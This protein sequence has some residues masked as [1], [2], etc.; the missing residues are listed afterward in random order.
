MKKLFI[1]LFFTA[2][3]LMATSNKLIIDAKKFEGNDGKGVSIFTGD[4]KLRKQQDKLDSDRLEVYMSKKNANQKRVPLRY[5]A[6]GNVTFTII[7]QNNKQY[8][9]KG[10]KVIYYPQEDRYVIIGN[11]FI[12]EKVE[13]R[14]VYG[15]K[16]FIDQK[17]GEAKVNGTD[18]K[19]VRFIINLEDNKKDNGT[20]K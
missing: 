20:K 16:I 4:V 19:P 2:S 14:K 17:T 9:G 3:I 7:S 10:N 8:E 1:L 6:I 15:D 11:G 5:V 13:D 18:N 12:K